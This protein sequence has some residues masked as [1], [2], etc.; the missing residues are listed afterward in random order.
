ME[1][2]GDEIRRFLANS[3]G[4]SVQDSDEGTSAALT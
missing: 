4:E 3:L 2:T 1:T